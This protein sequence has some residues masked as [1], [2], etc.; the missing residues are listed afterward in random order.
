M[1]NSIQSNNARPAFGCTK[2]LYGRQIAEGL[3]R[4]GADAEEAATFV[5]KHAPAEGK[6]MG[7]GFVHHETLVTRLAIRI[8]D[9][10]ESLKA[11]GK[12]AFV[13]KHIPTNGQTFSDA[14]GNNASVPRE[15]LQ[16]ELESQIDDFSKLFRN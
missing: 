1:L 8:G 16:K 14:Y 3:V 5:L 12:D 7:D 6:T 15:T 4:R 13:Q 10:F 2:C 9:F 11:L